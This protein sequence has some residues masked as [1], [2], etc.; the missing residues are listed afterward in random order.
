[1]KTVSFEGWDRAQAV[2]ALWEA[3][4]VMRPGGTPTLEQ[5]RDFISKP[6]AYVDYVSGRAL[7][8]GVIDETWPLLP[9][10]L[11]DRDNGTGSMERIAKLINQ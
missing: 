6:R 11:Y 7:K 8:L 4:R 9:S 10:E 3:A 2:L 5:I 1:M